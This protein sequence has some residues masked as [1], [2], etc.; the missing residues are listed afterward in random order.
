M[1]VSGVQS[2]SVEAYLLTVT[3]QDGVVTSPIAAR[4]TSVLKPRHAR[5]ELG[6]HDQSAKCGSLSR[7]TWKSVGARLTWQ[8]RVVTSP[9]AVR[10]TSLDEAHQMRGDLG[11]QHTDASVWCPKSERGSILAHRDLARW[12]RDFPDCCAWD[13]RAEASSRATGAGK[14]RSKREVRQPL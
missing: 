1:Q 13:F 3:W 10:K 14:S 4:G 2:L 8:A 6:S 12:C 7:A 9:I 11:S 5:Q